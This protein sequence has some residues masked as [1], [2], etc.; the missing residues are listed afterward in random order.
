M[1]EYTAGWLQKLFLKDVSAWLINAL[2]M[3]VCGYVK[4]ATAKLYFFFSLKRENE[5]KA[6]IYFFKKKKKV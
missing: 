6:I 3:T 1:R 2:N 4:K 5:V